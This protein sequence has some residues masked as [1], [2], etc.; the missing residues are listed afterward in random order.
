MVLHILLHMRHHSPVSIATQA[1]HLISQIVW[2]LPGH[3][4]GLSVPV[5]VATRV[6]VPYLLP[7]SHL[8][9]HYINNKKKN[10]EKYVIFRTE[11]N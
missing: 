2:Q 1:L 8:D 5:V 11:Q 4:I 7:I 6:I 10:Y 9:P 3:L